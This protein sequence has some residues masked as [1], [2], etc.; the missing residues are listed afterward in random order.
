MTKNQVIK[1]GVRCADAPV[2]WD[3]WP[4]LT[5]LPRLWQLE[6]ACD[7]SQRLLSKHPQLCQRERG[8][9]QRPA[10]V[11][12]VTRVDKLSH[13]SLV[14]PTRLSPFTSKIW[15]PGSRFPVGDTSFLLGLT[16]RYK[17]Q[18]HWPLSAQGDKLGGFPGGYS[19][20][21]THSLR[22]SPSREHV[23]PPFTSKPPGGNYDGRLGVKT[24]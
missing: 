10:K 19:S 4:A 7:W 2:V 22:V 3:V 14:T 6:G 15:S 8:S 21:P 5:L 20:A 9:V 18:Q 1:G 17:H 24:W 16:A 11:K 23:A 13:L 12:G